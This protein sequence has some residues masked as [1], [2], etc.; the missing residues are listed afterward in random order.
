[1]NNNEIDRMEVL[2][3]LYRPRGTFPISVIGHNRNYQTQG[4]NNNNRNADDPNRA[5]GERY[6]DPDMFYQMDDSDMEE[7]GRVCTNSSF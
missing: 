6:E 7:Q 2:N 4:Y 5:N 3:F 1:M